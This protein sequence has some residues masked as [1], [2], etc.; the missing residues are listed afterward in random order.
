MY[1]ITVSHIN[2]GGQERVEVEELASESGSEIVNIQAASKCMPELSS[3]HGGSF[4]PI[5]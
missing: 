4:F 3:Y 1:A 5:K 2:F